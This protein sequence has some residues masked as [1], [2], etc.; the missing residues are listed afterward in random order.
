[1]TAMTV[2][3]MKAELA[4]LNPAPVQPDV[5]TEGLVVA[6]VIAGTAA[7][8]V[9]LVENAGSDTLS[10]FDRVKTGYQFQ[11]AIDTGKITPPDAAPAAPAPRVKRIAKGH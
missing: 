2:A 11:R 4:K 10:F 9:K 8:V 5:F 7:G 1:M 6:D 3:Y